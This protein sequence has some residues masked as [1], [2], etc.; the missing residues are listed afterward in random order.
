[1]N[2]SE[3]TKYVLKNNGQA[4]LSG[5]WKEDVRSIFT[6]IKKEFRTFKQ[7]SHTTKSGFMSLK[8]NT[9]DSFHILSELPHRLKCGFGIFREGFIDELEHF[10]DPKDR[11][12]FTMKVIGAMTSFAVGTMY[13]LRKTKPD[14]HIPGLNKRSAFAQ[15]MVTEMVIRLSYLFILRFIGE[16]EDQVSD[17]EDLKK[18]RFFKHLLTGKDGTKKPEG[19]K[20]DP[21][22]KA[23]QLVDSFKNYIMT[24]K[25]S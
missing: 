6:D 8:E 25:E 12:V 18:L 17:P 19:W 23:F 24:G 16:I 21:E 11:T 13:E 1:M 7:K 20:D 2:L 15:F 22:D 14:I 9:I 3:S 5:F 10:H 4:L